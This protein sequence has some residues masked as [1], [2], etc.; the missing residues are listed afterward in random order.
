MDFRIFILG[1][2][3]GNKGIW[4]IWFWKF[5]KGIRES[6][7]RKMFWRKFRCFK[8]NFYGIRGFIFYNFNDYLLFKNL[9]MIVIENEQ[10]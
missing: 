6:E 8:R 7:M 1:V 2:L 9:M 4:G 3:F 5:W 10:N